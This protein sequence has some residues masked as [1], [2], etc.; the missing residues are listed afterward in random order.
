MT[1]EFEI[2]KR[3]VAKAQAEVDAADAPVLREP[4][5]GPRKELGG[6]NLTDRRINQLAKLSTLLVGNC[7]Q[8]ILNLRDTFP[9]ESHN[10]DVGDPSDPGVADQLEIM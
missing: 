1:N 2:N 7:S 9:H 8:Q 6:F 3:L 4:D 5:P 10:G